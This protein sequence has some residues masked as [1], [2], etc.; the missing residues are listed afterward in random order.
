ML[1]VRLSVEESRWNTAI[2]RADHGL[3]PGFGG[4][5][6]PAR[7]GEGVAGAGRAAGVYAALVQRSDRVAAEGVVS[8]GVV[9]GGTLPVAITRWIQPA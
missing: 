8:A 9:R 2:T 3:R 5:L 4:S 7:P 6:L 1:Q